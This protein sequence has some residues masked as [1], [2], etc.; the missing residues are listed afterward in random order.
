MR[1]L[2]K[3]EWRRQGCQDLGT[4]GSTW[5]SGLRLSFHGMDPRRYAEETNKPEMAIG[6]NKKCPTKDY[7]L[8]PQKWKKSCL[9]GWKICR[10]LPLY[11]CQIPYSKLRTLPTPAKM[12]GEPRFSL[13]PGCHEALKPASSPI[14]TVSEK[15]SQ[16]V[17][18]PL[19]SSLE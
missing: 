3:V 19:P 13:S 4:Q 14:K 12:K 11:S 9:A 7:S 8:S 16:G 18:D 15:A 5:W 1:R 2:W 17:W 10:Q 6:T